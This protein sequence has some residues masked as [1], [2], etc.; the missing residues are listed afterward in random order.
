MGVCGFVPALLC[1][2]VCCW[3]CVERVARR[4][5]CV[6]VFVVVGGDCVEGYLVASAASR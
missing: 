1:F 6:C 4:M 2:S 3:A 5:V